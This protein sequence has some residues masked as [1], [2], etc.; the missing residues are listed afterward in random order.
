VASGAPA[1]GVR[2]RTAGP[3]HV[4]PRSDRPRVPRPHHDAMRGVLAGAL[5]FPRGGGRA[6]A[7]AALGGDPATRAAAPVE[8][9]PLA[10]D[11]RRVITLAVSLEI[12]FHGPEYHS[13]DAMPPDLRQE[14]DLALGTLTKSR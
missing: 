1:R 7:R 3:G 5:R 8:R 13:V 6:P 12:V 2:E 11:L 9:A 14:Y 10:S 4:G